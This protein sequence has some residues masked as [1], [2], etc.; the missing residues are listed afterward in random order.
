MTRENRSKFVAP[1]LTISL[2]IGMTLSGTYSNSR[3][4]AITAGNVTQSDRQEWG[5]NTNFAF[6]LP[7]FLFRTST[8][9]QTTL[10]YNTSILAVCILTTGEDQCV[11][12]SDSRREQ[13]DIRMTSGLSQNLR[14]GLTFS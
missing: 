7:G 9:I 11:T 8:R 13:F 12:V 6:Q 1:S 2:P 5:A 4:E 3:S 10:G 14:G